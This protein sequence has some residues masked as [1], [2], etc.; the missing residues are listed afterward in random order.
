VIQ[1]VR[2]L[3]QRLPELFADRRFTRVWIAQVITVAAFHVS[4]LAF[5]IAGT[6]LLHAT[7]SQMGG[8]IAAQAL[9]FALFSLP[10]GVWVDRVAR[11]RLIRVCLVGLGLAIASVPLAWYAGVLSLWTLY[12]AGFV[13]GSV[14]TLFGTAHQVLVTHTV[15]RDRLVGAYRIISTTESIIRM[16]APAAA[17]LLI[18][19]LG[20]PPALLLEVAALAVAWWVF[21]HIAEPK[22]T[23]EFAVA[24]AQS[25]ASK[26]SMWPSIREGLAH[27]WHDPA[28]RAIAVCAA[29]WQVLF[30]GFQALQVLY[31]TRELHMSPAQ[32]GLA[33]M[34]GG[35]GALLAGLSLGR[36]NRHL[37][38]G[39]TLPLGLALTGV[40][41]ALFALLPHHPG[42]N[43]LSMGLVMFVFDFGCVA[44]FVNYISL[45]QI[46]TPNAL[47]GRVTATMR[48]ASVSLAPLGALGLG[49]LAEVTSLRAAFATMGVLGL[50]VAFALHSRREV[51]EATEAAI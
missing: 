11:T 36:I 32:I 21:L 22:P 47:L 48:F 31:A 4:H 5:P 16:A 40:A 42:L 10:S 3:Q 7:P 41:W 23:A 17:G 6:V 44:F 35:V 9:P 12:A 2:L 34:C 28:L 46:V 27:V 1:L 8:L 20:A 24:Q 45:R 39:R 50:G 38:P 37:G 43:V 19:W 18:G 26:S 15:G 13:V 49:W 25:E 30:H 29:A 33:H 14:N 51:R